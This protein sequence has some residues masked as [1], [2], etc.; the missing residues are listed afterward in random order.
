MK[1]R[2]NTVRPFLAAIAMSLAL[3]ACLGRTPTV[4]VFPTHQE[5]LPTDWGRVG[6]HIMVDLVVENGCLRAKGPSPS[7][8]LI[9]PEGFTMNRVDGSIHVSDRG[10]GAVALVGDTVRFSGRLIDPKSDLAVRWQTAYR[11]SAQVLTTW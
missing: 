6:D 7:Y 10:D 4:D 1:L 8:L 11:M 5:Q 3:T 9:W 2:M